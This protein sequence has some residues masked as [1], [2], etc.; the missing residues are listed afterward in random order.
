MRCRLCNTQ[1]TNC[2]TCP[3]NPKAKSVKPRKHKLQYGGNQNKNQVID[4]AIKLIKSQPDEFLSELAYQA[5]KR[6]LVVVNED[7]WEDL[8]YKAYRKYA[9]NHITRFVNHNNYPTVKIAG[10][11]F[12]KYIGDLINGPDGTWEGPCLEET[13]N[14]TQNF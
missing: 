8:F 1:G 10:M 7:M 3:L 2:S 11:Y 13:V 14:L 4:E 5:T 6:G 12:A 9:K